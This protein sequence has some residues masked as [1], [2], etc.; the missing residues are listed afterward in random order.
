MSEEQKKE[1]TPETP[2]AVE[3]PPAVEAPAAVPA[4]PATQA[5]AKTTRRRAPSVDKVAARHQKVLAD[6]LTQAAPATAKAPAAKAAKAAKTQGFCKVA[7]KP[8]PAKP[9][10]TPRAV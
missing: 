1:V 4:A 6:A 7:A 5:A 10:A 8:S 9:A 3:T 2:A